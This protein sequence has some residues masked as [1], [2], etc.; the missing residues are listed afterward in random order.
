MKDANLHL[1]YSHNHWANDET[2]AEWLDSV[3]L[4][5]I[6]DGRRKENENRAAEGLPPLL[7]DQQMFLLIVDLFACWTTEY[8]KSKCRENFVIVLY[9]PPEQTGNL[10]PLV[11]FIPF[12]H[13][14]FVLLLH[15]HYDRRLA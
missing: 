10:Q 6:S 7:P 13:C 2:T 9:V 1:S 4:P 14:P 11:H 5:F 12:F 15:P 3:F 8:F